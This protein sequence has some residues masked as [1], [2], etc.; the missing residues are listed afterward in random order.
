[1]MQGV[2]TA[3]GPEGAY[4]SEFCLF[5]IHGQKKKKNLIYAEIHR[6][7]LLPVITVLRL[8]FRCPPRTTNSIKPQGHSQGPLGSWLQHFLF[9]KCKAITTTWSTWYPLHTHSHLTNQVRPAPSSQ[10]TKQVPPRRRQYSYRCKSPLHQLSIS[11]SSD[12]AS[13]RRGNQHSQLAAH[14]AGIVALAREARNADAESRVSLIETADITSVK[15]RGV[16]PT[17]ST[18]MCESGRLP[19][20]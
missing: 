10:G 13:R 16:Q 6:V 15:E 12:Q 2:R 9:R 18:W 4:E 14:Q 1:M 5:H 3:T 8:F 19:R 7:S 11:H 20:A 17:S